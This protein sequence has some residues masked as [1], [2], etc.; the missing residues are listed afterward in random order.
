MSADGLNVISSSEPMG[1]LKKSSASI[2]FIPTDEL[3]RRFLCA[4]IKTRDQTFMLVHK[5]CNAEDKRTT[6]ES[7]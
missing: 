6:K 7:L 5:E 1:R 4:G 2:L 3:P